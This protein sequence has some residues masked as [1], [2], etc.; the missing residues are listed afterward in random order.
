MQGCWKS[1]E[2]DE[3]FV[4]ETPRN[5]QRNYYNSI[6][7]SIEDKRQWA[8]SLLLKELVLLVMIFANSEWMRQLSCILRGV[9][10]KIQLPHSCHNTRNKEGGPCRPSTWW[11]YK[12]RQGLQ[13]L[14]L[15]TMI[16]NTC[17]YVNWGCVCLFLVETL[18]TRSPILSLQHLQYYYKYKPGHFIECRSWKISLVVAHSSHPARECCVYCLTGGWSIGGY[19][20]PPFY[21]SGLYEESPQCDL[22]HCGF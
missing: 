12:N 20:P 8:S 14:K 9:H 17:E 18:L 19:R 15:I 6:R 5:I 21:V 2:E 4:K 7:T 22:V 3:F 16:I 13:S 1:S 11:H 10:K